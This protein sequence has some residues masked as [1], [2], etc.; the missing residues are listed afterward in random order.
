MTK[1]ITEIAEIFI[2]NICKE[3]SEGKTFT[4]IE[5]VMLKEAKECAVKL[6]EA[7]ISYIDAQI[8]S[9]K[10]GRREAGYSVERRND[11]RQLYTQLGEVTYSRT[12]YKKAAGGYEYLADTFM[13][14]ESRERISEGLSLSLINAAKDMP[15][16]K[17][18]NHLT[19]GEISRQTVMSRVRWSEAIATEL[20]EKRCVP[21]L[22]IDA[23]EAHVTLCSGK[24][25]KCR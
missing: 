10:S 20:R 9:D 25:A 19:G 13:G 16:E 1:I 14:V 7:Y 18:S 8:L 3:L 12:Y 5:S 21:E 6:T 17:A 24:K 11:K 22:H 4:Q 23:D 2:K 15:Y